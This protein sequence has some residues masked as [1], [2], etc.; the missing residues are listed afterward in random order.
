MI[1][2]IRTLGTIVGYAALVTPKLNS[3]KKSLVNYD[4]VAE[5]DLVTN[6]YPKKWADKILKTAGVKVKV[7]GNQNYPENGVLFISNHEGNFDIPV[8]IYAINKPFGFVSKVEVKKIPFLHKWMDLLNC[9]Y[10]DRTDRRSSIQM[11]R[12]GVA[13][14]KEGHSIMIF[15]EGTR[16]KG[17][18]MAEFKAGSFKLAKSAGV[19]IIPIAIKGTSQ[20]M[21][22]YNSKKIVPGH[23]DVTILDAIE[24]DIFDRYSLQEVANLVHERIETAMK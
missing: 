23:V 9:I 5:K 7:H 12:D 8:L 22:K 15:P 19:P 10:L 14:L 6:Q 16:S 3:V 2:L 20:L 4:T 17:R 24:P 13:S 11:I 1:R 18:G 21:E